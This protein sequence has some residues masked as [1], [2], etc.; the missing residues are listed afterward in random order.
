PRSAATQ[1]PP[2]APPQQQQQQQ[3]MFS[4][5]RPDRRHVTSSAR[6]AG[7]HAGEDS[8]EQQRLLFPLKTSVSGQQQPPRVIR[9]RPT[10]APVAGSSLP[11][12]RQRGGVAVNDPMAPLHARR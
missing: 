1:R 2:R 8:R 9:S 12:E 3:Q 6:A 11:Q 10:S 7:A 5:S 4:R